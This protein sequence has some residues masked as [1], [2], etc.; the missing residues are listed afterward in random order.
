MAVNESP[1]AL[2][3]FNLLKTGSW[4]E[5]RMKEALKPFSLTHS[6]LNVL[7]ILNSRHPKPVSPNEIKEEILVNNPDITR[8]LDRLVSKGYVNREVCPE[9]RRRIDVTLTA[10][11]SKIFAEADKAARVAVNNFFEKQISVK[12]AN[13]LR[14]ILKKI[15]I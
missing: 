3:Y 13:E 4:I 11:G 6:Q 9:N 2:A 10:K 8:V 1:H 5:N 15:T 12:E 7:Y 14:S